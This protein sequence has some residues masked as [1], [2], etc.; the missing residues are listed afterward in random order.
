MIREVMLVD[1]D[2]FRCED[3]NSEI[4]QKGDQNEKA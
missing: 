3:V 1:A 4:K 2:S